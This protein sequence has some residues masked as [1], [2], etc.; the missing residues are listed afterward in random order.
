MPATREVLEDNRL[1]RDFVDDVVDAFVRAADKGNGLIIN[2][3]TATET[4]VN[5][6]YAT[7]ARVAGV[8]RAATLA[9]A[10]A[11][12]LARSSLDPSRA[13][14]QLGWKPWTDLAA[15]SA[16]V[17]DFFRRRNETS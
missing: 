2:I 5:D 16:A 17:L 11:G 1:R 14:M 10:R 4:S 8:D 15:G 9:P 7:M 6:L 3:G 13:E 12:E